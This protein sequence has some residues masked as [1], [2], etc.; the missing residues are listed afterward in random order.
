MKNE[1]LNTF[2]NYYLELSFLKSYLKYK[3]NFRVNIVI[4]LDI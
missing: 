3:K 1:L 4:D 2:S